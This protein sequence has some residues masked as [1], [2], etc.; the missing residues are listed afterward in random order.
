MIAL[1]YG[2]RRGEV[3]GL[4]WSAVD[5]DA[6]TVSVTHGVKRIKS[7]DG[8]A[9]GR[10]RLVV[11]E[12]KTPKSRRTLALTPEIM[13][14]LRQHSARQAESKISAGT[15]WRDHGLIF[16]T[17]LGSQSTRTTSRTSSRS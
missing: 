7:R 8:S 14:K 6:G 16:V 12:L 3:L 9:E 4:R 1:A 2:M 5:W 15:L 11:G 13:A 10:T 17:E